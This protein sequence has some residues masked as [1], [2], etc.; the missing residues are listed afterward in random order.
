MR[1]RLTGV[2][3]VLLAATAL[4][5]HAEAKKFRYASG[6]K[7]PED[8]VLAVAH[9]YLEP[10]V[11][12]RGPRVPF[13]NLQLTELAAD[14]AAAHAVLALPLESGSRVVLAPAHDHPLNFVA[15]HSLLV[16]LNRR[17]IEVS[18]RHLPVADDSLKLVSAE[19]GDPIV[20]YTLASAKISYLRLVGW[21]PGRVKVERQAL[22]QGSLAMRDPATTRT[23]WSGDFSHNFVDRIPRGQVPTVE[24]SHYPDLKDAIPGRNIDKASEPVIVV[25][26]VGGLV[27]LFFQNRP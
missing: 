9:P 19:G 18:V 20:E 17:G 22:V 15:E 5:P 25:A 27:A 3:L 6:P 16:Q 24:D 13:T 23:V 2:L 14:S 4:A 7:A 12:A 10:L 1:S 26:I 8:S 11:Q 21:L